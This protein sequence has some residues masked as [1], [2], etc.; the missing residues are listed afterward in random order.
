MS[1]HLR[2][3]T[4]LFL[5]VFFGQTQLSS[6]Q[7]R[8][9][10]Q[11]FKLG[12]RSEYFSRTLSSEVE[13]ETPQ[14]TAY[15]IN[16]ALRYNLRAGF[17]LAVLLGYAS[18]NYQE[19]VFRQLPFSIDFEGSGI[20]GFVIGT[21]VEKSLFSQSSFEVDVLGQFLACLGIKKEFDIPD[22]VVPGSIK[23]RPSWMRA[24]VGPVFVLTSWEG[25][26]PYIYPCYDYLWGTFSMDQTVQSLE[27]TE[28]K[29]IKAKSQFGVLFGTGLKISEKFE[30]KAEAGLY[31][32]QGGADYSVMLQGLFSF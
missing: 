13:G 32:R 28:K 14:F 23:A 5:A 19:L 6:D 17:S 8:L 24:A 10:S 11:S 7:F 16:L 15:L 29:E 20:S 9:E 30:L 4:V 21:E 31:P 12:L 3:L 25:I 22:L 18:S 1:K 26:R 27:G 2:L